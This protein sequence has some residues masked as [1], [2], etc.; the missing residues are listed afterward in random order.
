MIIFFKIFFRCQ[1][2]FY[3]SV[4]RPDGLLIWFQKNL[5]KKIYQNY[6]KPDIWSPVKDSR[7]PLSPKGL[8][9]TVIIFI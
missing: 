5:H 1:D 3:V 8:S 7:P 6:Q 4:S 2:H 9:K